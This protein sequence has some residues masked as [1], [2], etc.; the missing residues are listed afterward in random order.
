MS[1]LQDFVENERVAWWNNFDAAHRGSINGAARAGFF[2]DV[3][4]V[5]G[6]GTGWRLHIASAAATG[7]DKPGQGNQSKQADFLG[8][9]SAFQRSSSCLIAPL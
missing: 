2:G 4:R 3:F 8:Y 1:P 5:R 7:Q 6:C 9:S